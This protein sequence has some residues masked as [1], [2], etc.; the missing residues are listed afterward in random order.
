MHSRTEQDPES[1]TLTSSSE[2][3]IVTSIPST[4]TGNM[5]NSADG[6]GS[7]ATMAVNESSVGPVL[8]GTLG[9]LGFLAILCLA[10][11]AYKRHQRTGRGGRMRENR[12]IKNG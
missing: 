8:G 3:S 2:S 6:S 10:F 7:A 11:V 5:S 1:K 12:Y 4:S 9:G